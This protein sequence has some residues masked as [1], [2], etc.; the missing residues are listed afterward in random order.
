[1]KKRIFYIEDPHITGFFGTT[2]QNIIFRQKNFPRF[3]YLIDSVK[4]NANFEI[5][6]YSSFTDTSIITKLQWSIKKKLEFY[7]WRIFHGYA[8]IKLETH[9][10]KIE[11]EDVFFT[12]A[13]Q[14]SYQSNL[15]KSS[16]YER[17]SAQKIA[18]KNPDR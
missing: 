12:F 2:L 10:D 5:R 1:M 6:F 11:K 13:M 3:R 8:K 7:L 9:V 4:R 15:I 16:T 17:I 18:I 14:S